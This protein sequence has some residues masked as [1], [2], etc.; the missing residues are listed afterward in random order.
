MSMFVATKPIG[1]AN[2]APDII[3]AAASSLIKDLDVR[4]QFFVED[5]II[6]KEKN[7]YNAETRGAAYKSIG[8]FTFFI[9]FDF[10]TK[11]LAKGQERYAMDNS[12]NTNNLNQNTP[13]E[14]LVHKIK[15]I[16]EKCG[17]PCQKAEVH[18]EKGCMFS[19]AVYWHKDGD[20]GGS[21]I[22]VCFSNKPNW[23]TRIAVNTVLSFDDGWIS[24]K[25]AAE[26]DSLSFPAKHGDLWHSSTVF[27]RGPKA[28]D[29]HNDPITAADW[30]LLIRFSSS[31]RG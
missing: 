20:F 18:F 10:L 11:G 19:P 17:F 9:P 28:S 21:K 29:M 30:R 12:F 2:L 27:H 25:D 4:H 16:I 24:E 5:A 7:L 1:S 14:A 8:T 22:T 13:L 31:I 26:L 23:S 15:D 3:D 6:G